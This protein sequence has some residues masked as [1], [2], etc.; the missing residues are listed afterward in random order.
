MLLGSYTLLNI[1]RC[2]SPAFFEKKISVAGISFSIR[3]SELYFQKKIN[4][5]ECTTA[6]TAAICS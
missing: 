6:S 1:M 2:R 3:K 5:S 4:V